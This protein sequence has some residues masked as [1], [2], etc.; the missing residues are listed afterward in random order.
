MAKGGAFRIAI[1]VI[2]LPKDAK[3]GILGL[4]GK[5]Q[6]ISRTIPIVHNRGAKLIGVGLHRSAPPPV[7]QVGALSGLKKHQSK[8]S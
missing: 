4:K 2:T 3:V 8:Q 7:R 6:L 1:H 5:N